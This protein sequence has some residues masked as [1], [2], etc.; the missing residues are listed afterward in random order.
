MFILFTCIVILYSCIIICAVI[1][2]KKYSPKFT[3]QHKNTSCTVII[4]ARNE[5][6][7]IAHILEDLCNQT[8]PLHNIQI[9]VANDHSTDNTFQIAQNIAH[10][11]TTIQVLNMPKH[12]QGKKQTLQHTLPLATGQYILFTDADCRIPPTW[13]ATYVSHIQNKSGHFY[14]SSVTHHKEKSVLQQCFTLDFI[15]MVGVQG[16]LAKL[17]RAFS[18]NAANMC[19]SKE[20]Y[21][22]A[23]RTNTQYDSGDDVFLLHTAKQMYPKGIHFISHKNACVSTA[24]PQSLQTFISQRI[25]WSSKASGYTDID[26][27]IVSFAVY[28]MSFT[29]V[30]TFIFSIISDQYTTLAISLYSIKTLVDMALFLTI[31]PFFNKTKLMYL[32]PLFQFFYVFYITIIPIFAHIIPKQWKQ[33]NIR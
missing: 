7:N 17:G 28:S 9:L 27:L 29:L 23:Y 6:Q 15:A 25:R 1:A 4:A 18:C 20:F 24:A 31:L 26:A 22:S 16:G 10:K 12:V 2:W 21:D 13:V 14:F 11:N 8:Y 3:L 30:C 19:I 32:V 5:E 33:R